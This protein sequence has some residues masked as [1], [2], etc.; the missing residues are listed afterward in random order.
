MNR[1]SA[2]GPVKIR[3]DTCF[4]NNRSVTS[5][6]LKGITIAYFNCGCAME[7]RTRNF[8]LYQHIIYKDKSCHDNCNMIYFK[9]NIPTVGQ[10][11]SIKKK[12]KVQCIWV[13]EHVYI[14]GH[15]CL[16]EMI[17]YEYDGQ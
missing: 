16:N 2:R 6:V 13:L 15:W 9:L 10:N 14:K 4:Y 3:P 8:K 5:T 12:K 7:L 1:S 11:H 17:L